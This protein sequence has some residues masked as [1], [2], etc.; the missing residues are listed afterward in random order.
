MLPLGADGPP[1]GALGITRWARFGEASLSSGS[2]CVDAAALL[3][4]LRGPPY[5]LADLDLSILLAK[6]Q[7]LGDAAN[8]LT[9]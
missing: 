3:Q 2:R 1:L 9:T 4:I 8:P 6:C 7:T 5:A